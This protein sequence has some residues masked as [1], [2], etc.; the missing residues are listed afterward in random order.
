LTKQPGAPLFP[1][2]L[3]AFTISTCSASQATPIGTVCLLSSCFICAGIIDYLPQFFCS[4][5]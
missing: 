4:C 3:N 1:T 5:F 2:K